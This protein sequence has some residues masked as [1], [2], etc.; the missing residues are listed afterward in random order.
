[1][2]SEASNR[3][4]T[5]GYLGGGAGG[6][7]T[8]GAGGSR[9]G[10]AGAT[11]A[12]LGRRGGGG[13][14]GGLSGLTNC[15]PWVETGA[16]SLS[17]PQPFPGNNPSTKKNSSE[18]QRKPRS[19]Q[20]VREF[21]MSNLQRRKARLTSRQIKGQG[22][23]AFGQKKFDDAIKLYQQA[24]LACPVGP[25]CCSQDRCVL[26]SNLAQA[27]IRQGVP[28]FAE[29]NKQS[30]EQHSKVKGFTDPAGLGSREHFRAY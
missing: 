8:R 5:E 23:K 19:G 9:S 2:E 30:L 14:G 13:A 29:R 6:R 7:F 17:C 15:V 18:T 26:L 10:L 1:M 11:R 25:A 28:R 24:L 3:I 16:L 21:F 27:Q 20:S 22:N 4:T 12:L